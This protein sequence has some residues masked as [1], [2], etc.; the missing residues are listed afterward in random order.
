ME[1]ARHAD[2]ERL[3]QLHD[4][5]SALVEIGERLGHN[6]AVYRTNRWQLHLIRKAATDRGI[7][8]SKEVAE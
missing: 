8:L 7:S 3:R 4:H 2:P 1:N 5:Y 6:G